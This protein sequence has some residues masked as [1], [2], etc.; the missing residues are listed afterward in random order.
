MNPLT[1]KLIIPLSS[2]QRVSTD[3]PLRAL[4]VLSPPGN[5]AT[6]VRLRRLEG[7]QACLELVRNTFNMALTDGPRL[8]RLLEH[9]ANVVSRVPVKRLSY[10]RRLPVL[11]AARDA[12]LADVRG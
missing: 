5:R 9:S 12:I 6:S 4:Y 11:A 10:P 8:A 3:V 7:R 2:R 1:P